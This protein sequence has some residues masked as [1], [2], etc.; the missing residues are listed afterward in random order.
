MNL[1]SNALRWTTDR[2][3][4]KV[5]LKFSLASTPPFDDSCAFPTNS[6]LSPD[7]VDG[8]IAYLYTEVHDTGPGLS[9]EDVEKLFQRF[10]QASQ[11]GNK[12]FGGSGL[13]LYVCRKITEQMGGRIEVVSNFG[14]GACFRF[15]IRVRAANLGS[16]IPHP[17]SLAGRRRSSLEREHKAHILV[18]EGTYEIT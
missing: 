18:V 16:R 8:E 10:S 3:I 17:P 4:R 6:P 2:P 14:Q 13:G 11:K 5:T 15:F 9:R 1:T 7:M 12:V